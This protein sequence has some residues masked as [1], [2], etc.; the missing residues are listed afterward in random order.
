MEN[1]DTALILA[2]AGAALLAARAFRS[3]TGMVIDL[4]HELR[5]VIG[6]LYSSQRENT[7]L[8]TQVGDFDSRMAGVEERLN[9]LGQE[10]NLLKAELEAWRQQLLLR[11][12]SSDDELP[13]IVN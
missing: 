10:V 2:V 4:T 7:A 1:I 6:E 11:S 3:M 8:E 12:A 5:S 9:I 13:S